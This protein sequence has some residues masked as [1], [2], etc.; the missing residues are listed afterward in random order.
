MT[1]G[2]RILGLGAA[3][4]AV[5]FVGSVTGAFRPLL[6]SSGG[7][8]ERTAAGSDPLRFNAVIDAN[9]KHIAA[10]V[11]TPGDGTTYLGHL[12]A[13]NRVSDGIAPVAAST[14]QMTTN[15]HGLRIGLDGVLTTS[16]AID[17][18]LGTLATTAGT[19]GTRLAAVATRSAAITALLGTLGTATA[20]LGGSVR[21]IDVTAGTIAGDKLPV[22]RDRTRAIDHALPPGIP[23]VRR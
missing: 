9:A 5:A 16:R 6:Y 18:G 19:A 15:V 8:G 10:L 13:L 3:V 23:P 1:G 14:A 17:D 11:G 22:A 2:S 20:G 12:A 4:F 21:A 7:A